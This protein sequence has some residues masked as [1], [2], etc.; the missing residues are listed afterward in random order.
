MNR[1]CML[2]YA[3]CNFRLDI[4]RQKCLQDSCHLARLQR[5]YKIMM[6]VA[7]HE[8]VLHF[9]LRALQL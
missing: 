3:L 9:G 8:P 5:N 1:F 4:I 6:H 2:V 7:G